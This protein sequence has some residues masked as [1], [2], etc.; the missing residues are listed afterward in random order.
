MGIGPSCRYMAHNDTL[1]AGAHVILW[2]NRYLRCADTKTHVCGFPHVFARFLN[3][4]SSILAYV[5][6]YSIVRGSTGHVCGGTTWRTK[7]QAVTRL[8]V[9][10]QA[11]KR[12]IVDLQC[13]KNRAIMLTVCGNIWVA[14]VVYACVR[15]CTETDCACAILV[16]SQ[17]VW[18]CC[19][20]CGSIFRSEYMPDTCRYLSQDVRGNRDNRGRYIPETRDWRHSPNSDANSDLPRHVFS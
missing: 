15:D 6:V 1:W 16:L 11:H 7:Y 19:M 10:C 5:G 13:W 12:I 2:I 14:A 4:Y 17:T 18:V 20:I 9:Y 3:V 8:H